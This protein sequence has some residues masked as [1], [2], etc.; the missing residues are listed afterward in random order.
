MRF[1][2]TSGPIV[3]ERH[4]SIPPLSRIDLDGVL[5]LVREWRYFVLRAPRQTGKTTVLLALRDLLNRTGEYRCVYANVE[6]SQ[7]AREDVGAAMFAVLDEL[8]DRAARTLGDEFLEGVRLEAVDRHGPHRALRRALSGWAEADPR[9]LVLSSARSCAKAWKG[10]CATGSRKRR[11]TSPAAPRRRAIWWCSTAASA[12]G[13]TRFS[14][15]PNAQRAR[16]FTSGACRQHPERRRHR[17]Y[18]RGARRKKC[19]RYR[20]TSRYR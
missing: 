6:C 20:D 4:Y 1:F 3:P 19:R 7:T 18:E 11:P 5:R 2:N 16:P 8:A 12:I 14:T 13:P 10:L 9:P 17:R 15:A